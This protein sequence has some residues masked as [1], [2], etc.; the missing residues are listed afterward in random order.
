MS[1]KR[2]GVT[3]LFEW[4]HSP[5]PRHR[6]EIK[7]VFRRYYYNDSISH[8][9]A[10]CLCFV[11]NIILFFMSKKF[12]MQEPSKHIS[13]WKWGS[14]SKM[15]FCERIPIPKYE[16]TCFPRGK[17]HSRYTRCSPASIT[18]PPTR[19]QGK[20]DRGTCGTWSWKCRQFGRTA[21]WSDPHLRQVSEDADG[22]RI[23]VREVVRGGVAGVECHWPGH[24][25]C[26]YTRGGRVRGGNSRG[27]T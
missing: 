2:W 4:S 14:S 15:W 16:I 22:A 13:V 20:A 7:W 8:S 19:L 9:K 21:R 17:R 24:L 6:V 26:H 12:C 1:C 18:G 5:N 3:I 27:E 23:E 11:E 25:A 10:I